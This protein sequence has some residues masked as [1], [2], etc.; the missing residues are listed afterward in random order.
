MIPVGR[1]KTTTEDD[2]KSKDDKVSKSKSSSTR[3]RVVAARLIWLV[4]VVCASVLAVAALLIAVEAEPDNP[5]VELVLNLAD[6]VDLGVF[7]LDNPIKR[8]EG[9][10]GE[11]TT[12][13][14][15]Y[16]IGAVVYLVLGRLIEQLVRP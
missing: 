16:G 7:D 15:N 1:R 6:G 11:T 3:P 14:F 12:A 2:D 9:D 5:L 10:N 4:F 8:F 13:L